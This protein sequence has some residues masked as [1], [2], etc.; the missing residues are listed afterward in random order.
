MSAPATPTAADL[1]WQ[2]K[3]DPRLP[4]AVQLPTGTVTFLFTDVEGSMRLLNAHADTYRAAVRRHHDLLRAAIEG[5][6]GVVF[7]TVGDAVY[8][9]FTQPTSAVAAA[10]EGQ[11]ALER[12]PWG[13]G[14]PVRVRAGLHTGEVERQG[15]H[16]F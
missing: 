5:H 1:H 3:V 7:E 14:G 12:E 4:V 6:E 10:I 13:E 9:A 16:Y 11:R 2:P 15:T 8:A